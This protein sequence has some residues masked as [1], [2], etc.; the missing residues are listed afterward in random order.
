M[1]RSSYNLSESEYHLGGE[2][3]MRWMALVMAAALISVSAAGCAGT[4]PGER[5]VPD[6]SGSRLAVVASFSV[7]GDFVHAVGGDLVT[8]TTLVGP[9]GDAHTFEPTPK[10]SVALAHASVLVENGLG[11]EP[12]LDDLYAAAGS[13]AVRVVA[14]QGVT[15]QPAAEEAGAALD[16]H[17]E[18][19]PHVW[20]DV[21]NAIVMV[22]TI[23]DG[24]SK[25]DAA[26]ADS[27]AQ[28]AEAYIARLNELDAF[29]QQQVATLAPERRKLVTSH[30]TFGY[31]ARRYG[32]ELVGTA[33]GS[34]STEVADPSAAQTAELVSTIKAAGVPAIFAENV[35][36]PAL[37]ETIAREAGV[38]VGPPLYS[39]ALGE[40]G[41]PGATYIEM[42]RYNTV[43]IVSALK[44]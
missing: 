37:V 24:L 14:T 4:Q 20:H 10:E 26:H 30:D 19:D 39:D 42:M 28:N 11:F 34:L 22:R 38:K 21:A 2:A 31:Y 27:Y 40:P 29:V 1:G 41:S 18:L 44:G 23:A 16:S 35:S 15:A 12:W 8:V 7:L 5:A 32:F 6:E 3:G 17:G 25:A 13:Q 9:G 36:N 43:A 33:L